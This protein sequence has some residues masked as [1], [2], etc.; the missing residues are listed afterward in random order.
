MR[1]A[2]R[3][4]DFLLAT[5]DGLRVNG[6]HFLVFIRD[7]NDERGPRLGIT[8]T[9]K[10]GNAVFRNRIKRLVRE[11]FRLRQTRFG[12]R[13][14]VVIAHRGI[15]RELTLARVEQDLSQVLEQLCELPAKVPRSP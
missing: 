11:W 1:P 12:S 2:L 6:A 8:V 14:L 5:R 15:P 4:A 3:R 13:D 10:V 9:R 7:R